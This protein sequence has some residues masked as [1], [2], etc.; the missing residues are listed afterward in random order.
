[1]NKMSHDEKD[2][3]LQGSK[4]LLVEDEESLAVGLEYNLTEEGF[5]VTIAS[6]GLE[7]I[8]SLDSQFNNTS[9][10]LESQ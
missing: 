4:I 1:M 6:D 8:K 10:I 7:A 2:H 9:I 5:S 3:L